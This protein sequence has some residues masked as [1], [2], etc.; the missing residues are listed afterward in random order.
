M[1][2]VDNP[3][4]CHHFYGGIRAAHP[5]D[6]TPVRCSATMIKQ[7]AFGKEE[8]A[9]TDAGCQVC[10]LILPGNPVKQALI[11]PFAARP[12]Q[13]EY[14]EVGDSQSLRVASQVALPGR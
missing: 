9:C 3:C 14:Q 4:I 10:V 7:A 11:M 8:G 13:P 5:L 6:T 2:L 1:S 12:G